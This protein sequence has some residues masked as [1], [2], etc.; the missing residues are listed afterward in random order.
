MTPATPNAAMAIRLATFN[1]RIAAAYDRKPAM[2]DPPAAQTTCT[3]RLPTPNGDRRQWVGC[4][5]WPRFYADVN[6]R[7]RF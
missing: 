2:T 3:T 6:V 7:G 5:P 4:G 1:A